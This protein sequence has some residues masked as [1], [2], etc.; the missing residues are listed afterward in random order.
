ME[1]SSRSS[2]GFPR[3]LSP[4]PT[5]IPRFSNYG[6][7][8]KRYVRT[9]YQPTSPNSRTCSR[10]SNQFNREQLP[11]RH[12]PRHSAQ[13][14]RLNLRHLHFRLAMPPRR[15][16]RESQSLITS[17]IGVIP[18]QL[19]AHAKNFPPREAL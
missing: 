5:P 17:P 16:N 7:A 8:S 14:P 12:H 13:R 3:K 10:T 18:N 19:I 1:P 2:N 4:A 6:A 9:R 11:Q 15:R